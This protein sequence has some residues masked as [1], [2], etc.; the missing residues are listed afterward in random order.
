MS[1]S[2]QTN[3]DYLGADSIWR[4]PPNSSR[5]AAD[6]ETRM[7]L[8]SLLSAREERMHAGQ[9]A[10]WPHQQASVSTETRT[11]L[12]QNPAVQPQLQQPMLREQTPG[13]QPY[14]EYLG[15]P[16]TRRSG[17]HSS[18]QPPMTAPA[19]DT[20]FRQE[21]QSRNIMMPPV[22]L[23]Q[24]PIDHIAIHLA[25]YEGHPRKWD[26]TNTGRP[27]RRNC[28]IIVQ[29]GTQMDK[30]REFCCIATP[31][32]WPLRQV[33]FYSSPEMPDPRLT[34]PGLMAMQFIAWL[35]SAQIAE[36]DTYMKTWRGRVEDSWTHTTWIGIYLEHL[37]KQRLITQGQM[38]RTK[39][40]QHEV[41]QLPYTVDLPND[42]QCFPHLY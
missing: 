33:L 30:F 31:L 22:Q 24:P 10:S 19:N 4:D 20:F 40:F 42:R 23:P 16:P 39:V 15:R 8:L 13:G 2:S 38:E 12:Q 25:I 37:L 7:E 35:P 3:P 18:M 9:S 11:S 29:Y 17:H 28:S 6:L 1:Q 21:L 41:F 5:S 27:Q 36:L 14:L 32:R 34:A 26:P